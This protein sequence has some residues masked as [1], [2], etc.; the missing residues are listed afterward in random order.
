MAGARQKNQ[1]LLCPFK[2][3]LI[4]PN[5][6]HEHEHSVK[7]ILNRDG[8][9]AD[10]KVVCIVIHHHRAV[11]KTTSEYAVGEDKRDKDK[12]VTKEKQKA[13]GTLYKPPQ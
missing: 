6:E 11:E 9:D 12:K 5:I 4:A 8:E 3:A 2:I 13:L 1:K 10:A 7:S